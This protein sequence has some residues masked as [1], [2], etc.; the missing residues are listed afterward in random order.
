MDPSQV[1]V[2]PDFF[3]LIQGLESAKYFTISVWQKWLRQ[4]DTD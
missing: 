2:D 1:D 3:Q 4:M